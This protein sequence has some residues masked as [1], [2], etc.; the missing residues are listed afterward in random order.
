M[1]SNSDRTHANLIE[2]SIKFNHYIL[3]MAC[4]KIEAMCTAPEYKQIKY[5]KTNFKYLCESSKIIF[6][7]FVKNLIGIFDEFD[8]E[9]AYLAVECFRQ[10]LTTAVKLYER[11]IDQFLIYMRKFTARRVRFYQFLYNYFATGSNAATTAAARD[12]ASVLNVLHSTFDQILLNADKIDEDEDATKI[13]FKL[14]Q[15]MEILHDNV[16]LTDDDQMMVSSVPYSL[17]PFD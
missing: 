16:A 15:C 5:S 6:V 13:P 17:Y 7:H 9:M 8:A 2:A 10:C 3:G 14:L 12:G 11:K 4:A 1:L